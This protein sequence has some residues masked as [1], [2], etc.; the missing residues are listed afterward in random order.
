MK[1]LIPL[2]FA[3]VLAGCLGELPG[4]LRGDTELAGRVFPE[5]SPPLE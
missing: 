1:R 2:F 5:D 4:R 3:I